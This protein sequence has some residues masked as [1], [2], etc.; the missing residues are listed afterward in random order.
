MH[1]VSEQLIE[2]LWVQN[3]KSPGALRFITQRGTLTK[4]SVMKYIMN[5]VDTLG[6]PIK[7]VHFKKSV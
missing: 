6:G 2:Y 5:Y 7:T 1:I 4:S 3:T